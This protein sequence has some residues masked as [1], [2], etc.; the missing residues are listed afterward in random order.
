MN[1]QTQ[2]NK[3]YRHNE[4]DAYDDIQIQ[5]KAHT[6]IH[7]V[8]HVYTDILTGLRYA[9]RH[10]QAETDIDIYTDKQTYK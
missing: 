6:G 9:L 4:R 10:A 5:I 7:G 2:W 8:I 1:I 3:E